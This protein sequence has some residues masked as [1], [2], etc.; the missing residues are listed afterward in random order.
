MIRTFG[1]ASDEIKLK[2]VV[3]PVHPRTE[4]MIRTFGLASDEIKLIPP[5]DYLEFLQLERQASLILTDSGGIQEEA[6]ILHV[7]CVT[8]RENTE[9][10]SSIDV[11]ANILAGTDAQRIVAASRTMMARPRK[12]PNPYGDGRSGA[13]ILDHLICDEAVP[14]PTPTAIEPSPLDEMTNEPLL[15]E[16]SV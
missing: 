15:W 11:G 12:W 8:L 14:V 16:R 2:D 6:C 1:L 13:R 5:L 3:F 10:P 9:R 4:K 7:P